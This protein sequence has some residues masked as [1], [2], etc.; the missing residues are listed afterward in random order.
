MASDDD[1]GACGAFEIPVLITSH[2][3]VALEK[4]PPNYAS[5]KPTHSVYFV[6]ADDG[7]AIQNPH[8]S[9][10]HVSVHRLFDGKPYTPTWDD[11][12]FIKK[13]FWDDEDLAVQYHPPKSEHVNQFPWALHLWRHVSIEMPRPPK[14]LVGI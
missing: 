11:M 9:W 12:C 7:L 6:I 10:E 14:I 13:M 2:S 8:Y 4:E 3:I 5:K 1:F